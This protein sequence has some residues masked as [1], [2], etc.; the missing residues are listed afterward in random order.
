MMHFNNQAIR[1]C[2]NRRP[3]HW[4]DFVAFARAVARINKDWEMAQ[5]L[6]G[7]NDADVKSV[8]SVVGKCATTALRE[9]HVVIAFT[10]DV[11][12]SH[13]KLFQA[14][15]NAALQQHRL[16]RAPRALHQR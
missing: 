8:R 1:A 10:H 16:L 12:S 5:P 9:Y 4:R 11:L 7:W 13:E 14:S 15:R 2:R 3:R 6:N